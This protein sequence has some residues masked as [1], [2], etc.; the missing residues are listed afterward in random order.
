MTLKKSLSVF[1]ACVMLISIFSM[2]LTGIAASVDLNTQY[3]NLAAALKKDHVRDLTNYTI[4]N[5]ALQNATKGFNTEANGFAYEHR[6]VAADNADGDILKAA[7]IF[8]FIAENIMSTEYGSG[9]YSPELLV[10]E[11]TAK[12]KARF[13]PAG[14]EK[15]YEDFYGQRYIPTDEEL[16]AYNNAVALIQAAGRE[17]SQLSL[18][19]FGVY[20]MEKNYYEYYNVDTI[21]KY[22]MGNTVKVNAGNWYHRNVFIVNTSL[23]NVLISMGNV[24]NLPDSK[25]TTRTAAYEIDYTRT[26][27]EENTKAV[28]AF[29]APSAVTVRNNYNSGENNLF[30]S[31]KNSADLSKN[32][33]LTASGQA[34]G[35]FIKVDEDTT[36]IPHLINIR[37]MFGE[38]IDD[39]ATY[40]VDST[41]GAIKNVSNCWDSQFAKMNEAQIAAAVPNASE[42]VASFEELTNTYSNDALMAMFGEDIGDMITL[43]YILKPISQAPTREVRNGA[44]YTATADKLNAIVHDMDALV[45]DKDSDTAKNVATIVKQFFNTDNELFAGTAVAGMDFT[46]LNELVHHLL[47]GLLFRDSIVNM[48]IELLYPLVAD[49]IQDKVVGAVA[50]AVGDG[51]GDI[52]GD[53]LTN[54][55]NQN[56]L[57]LYPEDL[58]DRINRD[59]PGRFAEARAVLKAGGHSWDNVNFDAIVWG[60]DDAA[61]TEKAELFL[62]ALCAGLGGFM[63][64]VVTVMCGDSKFTENRGLSYDNDQFDSYFDKKLINILGITGWLRAQGGYTKLIVPLFRVLGIPEMEGEVTY[65]TPITGYVPPEYYHRIIAS[66]DSNGNYRYNYSLRLILA[67]IVYWA[68]NILAQRPFET[69]WAL[70]PNLVFFFT[71]Q[72]VSTTPLSDISAHNESETRNA[73]SSHGNHHDEDPMEKLDEWEELATYNL[74]TI[75][76]NIVILIDITVPI[77]FNKNFT[78]NIG[79]LASLIDKDEL[80]GSVNGLLNELLSLEYVVS[81]SGVLNPVAYKSNDGK[82]VL[83]SSVEYATNTANYPTALTT[84]YANKNETSFTETPDDE[85]TIKKEDPEY[86]KAPY[87]IPVLQEA[88]L[89]SVTTLNADGTLADPNAIG[90]LNT[91]WN[92]ITVMNP[93]VVLMYVLR[94]VL[95]AL[96]YKYDIS[97]NMLTQELPFLIECFGL[98]IDMELFQGL[99]LKDIIFNVMLHPDAAI[100]ALLE[101]FYS[102]EQGY[103]YKTGATPSGKAYTYPLTPIDYHNDVLLDDIINPG[104]LYG[105]KVR[106]SQY[107]TREYAEETLDDLDDLAENV[108]KILVGGEVIELEGFEDGISGFLKNLLNTNV[109]NNDLMNTL[110]NTIYQLLGGLNSTVGFDIE[111]ILDAALDIHYDTG[112]VG[113]TIEAMMG[114][115]TPASRAIK[116]ATSWNEIF[117][118]A[119][120][121]LTNEPLNDPIDVEFDWGIDTAEKPHYA[122]LKTAA[123]LLAPA[124]FAIRFL[125]M[126]QHLDILG[127]IDLNSYAGYQYAFIGLLEALSCPNILTYKEY[128]DKGQEKLEGTMIGDANTIYYLLE[129]VLGLVDQV[130]LDPLTTV[131][132]LVPNL[133]FFISIGGLNDLLNN[134]VHF[135]YVLL[136]ILKPIVNGY[137]LLS[138]LI[139]NINISGF[140]L[141][142]SLPL[143]LD[144]NALISDLLGTLVGDSLQISGVK[145]ALPYID[146]HTLCCGQLRKYDSA[147]VRKTVRL[148]S[149]DGADLITAI[150]RL[151]FE[152]V[153]MDEN[154]AALSQIIKNA[155]DNDA[156]DDFDLQTMQALLDKVFDIV[157]E[158]EV[159]DMVLYVVYFLVTKLT[160]ISDTLVASNVPIVSIIKDFDIKNPQPILDLI[161]TLTG[162]EDPEIPDGEIPIPDAGGMIV[163]KLAG[164]S[165]WAKIKAFF[166]K[167]IDFFKNLFS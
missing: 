155:I 15:Y 121:P 63:R 28:Y 23:D 152:I 64:A 33:G 27:I 113:R 24:N 105:T 97:D 52:V 158:Y 150:F 137:D 53:L 111:A 147:E 124:A 11:V 115:E 122:F 98:D 91:A 76:D 142:L 123:A 55:I 34:S 65:N 130:Y 117:Q 119:V 96:G 73:D 54:I 90:I 17:P 44:T 39:T 2:G 139:S 58:A 38:Y 7:N 149:A 95:S 31:Q 164:D 80:L 104:H 8:Y 42:L 144:F 120:D 108:L 51:L 18:T 94:F 107:W 103:E 135:A 146:F 57:A 19:E 74:L 134:L 1:L 141:N 126:D 87:K 127:L 25:I 60:I 16:E 9:L 112:I 128:Y 77:L 5:K 20:F 93:G 133:L 160:P 153:Y 21:I 6:V 67:P 68:E 59:Y 100:C 140:I 110:F 70:I 79:S 99:N 161:K 138:G 132:G 102:N 163:D 83:R 125:F 71:R 69:I 89:T 49:L 40:S 50:D 136:D 48:L 13:N 148:D 3:D 157:E 116:T 101:L 165:I 10:N 66:K 12:L 36:T 114:Y 75:L 78:I 109:F 156:I 159:L 61:Y 35:L 43:V 56:D 22:F 72:G 41:T 85:H 151:A 88:K 143:D 30:G 82:I 62:D 4:E 84:V 145:I 154:Q 129:P 131:L 45:Y 26:F 162:K 118:V 106:Y 81:E 167:I 32:G 46:D 29:T 14:D 86:I 47:V 92:T 37:T 166:Q